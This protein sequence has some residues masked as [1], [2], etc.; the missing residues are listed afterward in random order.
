MKNKELNIYFN[1]TIKLRKI[2]HVLYP[3]KVNLVPFW[4]ACTQGNNYHID[5]WCI[6][7]F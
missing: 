6:R 4:G 3:Q 5:P 1:L 2:C 7:R